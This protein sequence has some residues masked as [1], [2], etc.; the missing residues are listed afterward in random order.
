MGTLT[1]GGMSAGLL[2]GELAVGP[3]TTTGINQIGAVIPIGL[4]EGDN[5]IDMPTGASAVAV[6]LPQSPSGAVTFR[7]SANSGDAGL[8]IA[9]FSGVP[10]FKCDLVTGATTVILHAADP[11]PGCYVVFI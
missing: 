5:V 1:I 11:L 7:T 4:V 8:P 6:F 10:W 2:S 3:V 9:P